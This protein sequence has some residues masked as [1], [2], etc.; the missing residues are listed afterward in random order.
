M[1]KT[2][3][4]VEKLE[5]RAPVA[6]EHRD[7]IVDLSGR[8]F[9]SG[10]YFRWEDYCRNGYLDGSCYDWDLS[11]IAM[12]D[13]QILGHVGVW[14]YPMRI[15]TARVATGGIG[16]VMTHPRFRQMGIA[17]RTMRATIEAMREAGCSFSVLFGISNYYGRFGYVQ[18]FPDPV[19]EVPAAGLPEGPPRLKRK[20]AS[21]LDLLRARGEIGRLYDR[22]YGAQTGA[23]DRPVYRRK[24]RDWTVCTL[25]EGDSARAYLATKVDG[26]T[27]RVNEAA[28]VDGPGMGWELLA[29]IRRLA[30]QARCPRVAF[31]LGPG[32]PLMPY[33]RRNG[34][35]VHMEYVRDGGAMAL[36][37]NLRDALEAME[38]ELSTRLAAGTRADHRGNLAIRMDDQEVTLRL[39]DGRVRVGRGAAA[40]RI[41]GGPEIARLLLG[42]EVPREV[43][44]TGGIRCAGDGRALAEA[45]FP[46]RHPYLPKADW[47]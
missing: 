4:D 2:R 12:L 25:L 11:R 13:G 18:A 29:Q 6:R 20:A 35:R 24:L 5:F 43:I 17:E 19:A 21:L 15:G 14:R 26:E 31:Q 38:G 34:C 33:V 46:A 10:G 7:A 1:R 47:Y 40:D 23:A 30:G 36:L 16:I 28:G 3:I 32:H 44:D 42:S 22:D 8:I 37:L 9:G 27:L 41:E 39:A 45:L